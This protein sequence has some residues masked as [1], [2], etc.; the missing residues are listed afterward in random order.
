MSSFLNGIFTIFSYVLY[1]IFS[2]LDADI[3]YESDFFSSQ[4]VY[5]FSQWR[6]S[7]HFSIFSFTILVIAIVLIP[8]SVEGVLMLFE[9]INQVVEAV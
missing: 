5:A 1:S 8:L 2:T 7:F 9:P 4:I 6:D 3:T